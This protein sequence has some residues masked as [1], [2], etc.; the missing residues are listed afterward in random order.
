MNIRFKLPSIIYTW[1][2]IIIAYWFLTYL[3]PLLDLDLVREMVFMLVLVVLAECFTVTLPQGQISASFAVIFSSYLL[4]GPAG[5]VWITA[6]GSILGQVIANKRCSF[7]TK[8][9]NAS[10]YV[11]AIIGSDCIYIYLGGWI[12]Q[13]L[14]WENTIP[15]IS[16]TVTCFFI[17]QL[18]VYIYLFLEQKNYPLIYLRDT[19]K[20]DSITYL[21]TVPLGMFMAVLHNKIGLWGILLL[22]VPVLVMQFVLRLYIRLD[23]SNRQLQ[24]LYEISRSLGAGLS[25]EQVL[26]LILKEAGRIVRYHTGVVYIWAAEKECCEVAVVKGVYK[27][28]LKNSRVFLGQEFL[29]FLLESKDSAIIYDSKNDSRINSRI[30]SKPGIIQLHR[31][32]LVVPLLSGE[33]VLGQVVLGSRRVFAFKE[34]HRRMLYA[35]AR[36]AALAVD[37]MNLHEQVDVITKT[38]DL[39]GLSSQRSFLYYA[40]EKLSEI[41][42]RDGVVS[43]IN[44]DV[45]N[46]NKIN[47]YYGREAGDA[48]LSFFTRNISSEI[49]NLGTAARSGGDEFVVL[50][51]GI[52]EVAASNLAE[53]IMKGIQNGIVET[54]GSR[55]TF[56]A[57]LGLACYPRDAVDLDDLLCKGEHALR[58]AKKCGGNCIR[59]FSQMDREP[60]VAVFNK[61][62]DVGVK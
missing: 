33:K 54:G 32:L 44:V 45:D 28:Q 5:A 21:V 10:Q 22:F 25:L 35:V 39:T 14:A 41:D 30:N 23:S 12:T 57:S 16:F 20:W 3:F 11:L 26:N 49:K 13:R 61:K 43:L 7:Q 59:V 46:M 40:K 34:S 36:Q 27:Q 17:N 53:K 52:G 47:E 1:T 2:I 37:N 42:T 19:L 51:P 55:C 58:R 15:L 9:F 48:V 62:N 6:L 29:G 8:L 18:L 24:A 4:F 38:D 50:L 60:P 31:S 56:Q